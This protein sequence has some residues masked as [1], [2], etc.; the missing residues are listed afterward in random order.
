MFSAAALSN[1]NS[2]P[3]PIMQ[4]ERLLQSHAAGEPDLT[5]CLERFRQALP[6]MVMLVWRY[7][8]VALLGCTSTSTS[9]II[10]RMSLM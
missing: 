7:P 1:Q 4:V 6:R 8:G 2:R 5:R 10:L 9:A 3:S